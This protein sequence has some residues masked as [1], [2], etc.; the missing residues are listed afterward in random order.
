V[1]MPRAAARLDA[2]RVDAER[3]AFTITALVEAEAPALLNYFARRVRPVE[4]AADLLAQTMLVAWRRVKV[5]PRDPIQARMWLY[6]VA[7]NV[8][9]TH[10]RSSVR[11]S[12]LAD[13]LRDDLTARGGSVADETGADIQALVAALDEIDRELIGL[14]Y[15]EGFSVLEAAGILKIRAAT[16]RSRM[17]RARSQL[18]AAL[19][20]GE[21]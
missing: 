21:E 10:R 4:D 19:R 6:G 16:A 14:V 15:W 11:R 20:P 2:E 12:E 3:V 18:R 17:S 9:A 13:R 1:G 5:I 7:R 8:L